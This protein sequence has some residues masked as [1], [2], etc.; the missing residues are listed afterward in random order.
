[1]KITPSEKKWLKVQ[2]ELLITLMGREIKFLFNEAME[3][4][5]G[6]QRDIRFESIKIIKSWLRDIGINTDERKE[7]PN[8]FI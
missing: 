6:G 3:M 7:E 5:S 2:K 4:E 1:M 8:E